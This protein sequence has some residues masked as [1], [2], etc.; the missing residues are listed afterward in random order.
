MKKTVLGGL[1]AAF[2]L[3]AP[4]AMTATPAA[5]DAGKVELVKHGRGHHHGGHHGHHGWH[6]KH[7]KH[8]SYHGWKHRSHHWYPRYDRYR[9]YG[10]Y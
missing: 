2:L 3:A 9:W 5:A 6:G 8:H 4:M 10:W 1:A 7:H